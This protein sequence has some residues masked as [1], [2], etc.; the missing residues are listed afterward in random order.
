[1]QL[2]RNELVR[3]TGVGT[4][5]RREL[6]ALIAKLQQRFGAD[7]AVHSLAT[8][9][10]LLLS[11]DQ[12][13][14]MITPK[15]DNDP[16]R[17]AFLNEYL[18]RLSGKAPKGAHTVHWPTLVSLGA[19]TGIDTTAARAIQ[20]R[21]LNQWSRNKFITQLRND[22]AQL[23]TDNGGL[24]TAMELA[25]AILLRRGSVQPSPQRERMAQALARAA[26]E[27]E[28]SR[29]QSRWTLR[30]SGNR[31]LIADNTQGRGEEL[32]DYA[33]A[34]GQLADE[35]AQQQPLLSPVRALERI[36]AVAAP[37]S[38]AGLSNH[39][40][41][42]LAVAASQDAAL[43]SR[44]EFYPRGMAA[45][46]ALEL[47]QGALLGTRELSV[48][49]VIARIQGRYPAAQP[50][51]GRP[52]LD[53]LMEKLD[54]GF[55]WNATVARKGDR[56]AYCLPQAGLTSYAS[57]T[58]FSYTQPETGDLGAARDVEQ[59][60]SI[61]QNSLDS[62]RFLALSVRPSRWLHAKEKLRC[63]FDF[64]VISFDELLLRH[65]HQ[66]CDSM[67][68]PPKWE[69]VLKADASKTNSVDWSRLQM[70]V[71]KVLPNMADE[72]K[73]AGRPVLLTEPGLIARYD[74]INSWLS[75]LRQY[76]MNAQQA[77]ALVLLIANDAA[78]ASAVIDGVS[79]PSG[80]GSREFARIPSAW[81]MPPPADKQADKNYT[82][83]QR[84]TD[85]NAGNISS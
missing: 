18:G 68:K 3:M 45:E 58:S 25:E 54:L 70:L 9:D 62:A 2:P 78:T 26:V 76:L 53:T 80:A 8:T 13:F 20:T 32:A 67:R 79:V 36:R 15:T 85:A 47:A 1:M 23:L 17:S 34:L 4:Q 43:S 59:F 63:T 57:R 21:V 37:A 69:V 35:C 72:I 33:E 46:R 42:R 12:F 30:R 27:T 24:M 41:L 50:L 82:G 6:S 19:E 48:K 65:L 38:F 66:L 61:V 56:G 14:A 10:T 81:L 75:D 7:L 64:Q 31:M 55:Q 60:I 16:T 39:R 71:R 49:E 83:S 73:Q 29:Q 51:P 11:V 77:H 5:T 22:M 44:A 84:R 40:L 28:L 74:L 52:Q